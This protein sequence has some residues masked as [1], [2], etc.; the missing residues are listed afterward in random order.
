MRPSGLQLEL[1]VSI[2]FSNRDI[3][4]QPPHQRAE[5]KTGV[6]S[7]VVTSTESSEAIGVLTSFSSLSCICLCWFLW[8]VGQCC[9]HFSVGRKSSNTNAIPLRYNFQPNAIK[10]A[11]GKLCHKSKHI[12]FH[13]HISCFESTEPVPYYHIVWV[14]WAAG[15]WWWIAVHIGSVSV[16]EVLLPV[17]NMFCHRRL[18]WLFTHPAIA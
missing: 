18:D 8:L 5:I 17:H 15:E 9:Q 1:S 12:I 4:L 6:T 2:K 7:V 13:I 14:T 11:W 10:Q 3:M 16:I